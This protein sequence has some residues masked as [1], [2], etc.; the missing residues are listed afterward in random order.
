MRNKTR[1]KRR[2]FAFAMTAALSVAGGCVRDGRDGMGGSGVRHS[3][4][5]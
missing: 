4:I 5:R 2:V 3:G 1:W